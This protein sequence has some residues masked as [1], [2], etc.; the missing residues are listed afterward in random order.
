MLIHA[1][2]DDGSEAVIEALS[3]Y[4]EVAAWDR[5]LDAAVAFAVSGRPPDPDVILVKSTVPISQVDPDTGARRDRRLALLDALRRIRLARPSARVVLLLPLEFQEERSFLSALVAL[6]I[7]DFHFVSEFTEADLARWLAE[8][9]TLA[10]VQAYLPAPAPL[11]GPEPGQ[12]PAREARPRP[13]GPGMLAKFAGGVAQAGASLARLGRGAVVAARRKEQPPCQAPESLPPPAPSRHGLSG[14][15][16]AV[17]SAGREV[18]AP[19]CSGPDAQAQDGPQVSPAGV[20]ADAPCAAG[21]DPVPPPAAPRTEEEP[22]AAPAPRAGGRES[23]GRLAVPAP[24]PEPTANERRSVET[25][26]DREQ[27]DVYALGC[28][29]GLPGVVAFSERADF[30]EALARRKPAAVA[31]AAGFPGALDL[32]RELRAASRLADVAVGVVGEPDPAFVAAGADEC[33]EVLDPA[34]VARLLAR[35]ERLVAA[36]QEANTDYLTGLFLRRCLDPRLEDAGRLFRAHGLPYSVV[37]LDLDRFKQINDAHGHSAGDEVLRRLGDFLR[38]HLRPRDAAFR[39]GGEE[40]LLLLPGADLEEAARIA[41]RLRRGWEALD[42]YGSTFSA[43]VAQAG[44]HGDAPQALLEAADRALYAAKEAGRNRVVVAGREP[45]AR[46]AAPRRRAVPKEARVV[47]VASPSVRG[48]GASTVAAALARHLARQKRQVAAVDA[49][50]SGRGLGVRLG[51]EPHVARA[52][53]WRRAELPVYAGDVAVWP[54]GPGLEG[55]AGRDQIARVLAAA[56]GEAEFV[57]LDLGAEPDPALVAVADAFVWV[58]RPDPV[59]LERAA[60]WWP[61]R[62]QPPCYECLVLLGGRVT[63]RDVEA[64]QDAFQV[65][66]FP[67][68]SGEDARG[69]AGPV[70]FVSSPEARKGVRMLAVGYDRRPPAMP[71][72][73]WA[74]AP[75]LKTLKAWLACHRAELAVMPPGFRDAALARSHLERAGIPV[76]VAEYEELVRLAR[77]LVGDGGGRR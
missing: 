28:G 33:L 59:C 72:V 49:D 65:P 14:A 19:A 3:R 27:A 62:P 15:A 36:W 6:G 51:L 74:E 8:R 10:D 41:E 50:F 43:G 53:D 29:F 76:H 64:A 71:G 68:A 4:G 25:P 58:V 18:P 69:L 48:A 77:E 40:L 54:L 73:V 13:A 56:G 60:A 35:R 38:R 45:P 66:C 31:V 21:R 2:F 46:K 5:S 37:M 32:V 57:V 23:G 44:V 26:P 70:R 47:A 39:Y 42:V 34:G 16:S 63:G 11:R 55:D 20:A 1:V 61:A 12:A 17:V 52:C 67:V 75:A 9:R 24:A 7:Y 30:L 22:P